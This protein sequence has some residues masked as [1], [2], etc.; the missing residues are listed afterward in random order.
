MC[1][2]NEEH[3]QRVVE[4]TRTIRVVFGWDLEEGREGLLVAIDRRPDLLCYL[5]QLR[6]VSVDADIN[7]MVHTCWLMSRIA[8]SL[9]SVNS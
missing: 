4:E 9:R 7:V 5:H 6:C 1:A 2:V 8:T 3:V